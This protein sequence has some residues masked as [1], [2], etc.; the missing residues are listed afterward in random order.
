ME[1]LQDANRNDWTW[2]FGYGSLMWD[3]WQAE[4]GSLERANATLPGYRRAFNK[5]S[6]VNWGTR[7]APC[8][9]LNL[10][11]GTDVSCQGT[12]F[13][14]EAANEGAVLAHLQK[15]EGRSFALTPLSVELADGTPV[16][17]Y[18]PLYSGKNLR[19]DLTL[20]EQVRMIR[21]ARGS[22][23]SGADYVKGI[24]ARLDALGIDDPAVRELRDALALA[25]R[26]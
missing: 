13:A 4:V 1:P 26:T 12:A 14:F 23:G 9:T 18:T 8:P 5:L 21:A 24:A 11:Q 2:V 16:T 3:G 15:R 19:S 6:V 25:A 20:E 22:S 10:V 17:A 7:D